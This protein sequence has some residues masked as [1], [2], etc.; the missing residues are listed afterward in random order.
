MIYIYTF[1]ISLFALPLFAQ[2][3]IEAKLV[4]DKTAA[5]FEEAG[6]VKATFELEL[7]RKGVL[8]GQLT[9]TIQLKGEKFLLKTPEVTTWFDGQTQWSYL[10]GSDE[11]NVSTP[12]VAELQSMNPYMLLYTYKKGFSYKL[13]KTK[14]W[15]GKAIYEVVLSATAA[16][17]QQL[18]HVVLYVLKENYQPV[19]IQVEMPDD[20]SSKIMIPHYQTGLTYNDRVFAFDRSQYPTAEM[21]DLR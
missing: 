1:L 12:T 19:Y 3:P 14:Q 4:L 16:Q 17:K 15:R 10:G 6:G 21:I 9:G 8:Q 11:V 7:F 20:A 5:A 2:Q 18:S 13:G